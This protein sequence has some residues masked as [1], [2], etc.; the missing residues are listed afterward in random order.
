MQK[1]V[2]WNKGICHLSEEAKKRISEASKKRILL[3]GHPKGMLGKK[4][5]KKAI[6]KIKKWKPSLEQINKMAHRKS[7]HPGWKG[8]DVIS[9]CPICGKIIKSRPTELKKY[10][11]YKCLGISKRKPKNK[12]V[13]CGKILPR[14]ESK[15]C[16]VCN[17]KLKIGDKSHLWKGGISPINTRIRQSSKFKKWRKSV[18]ERDKYTCQSCFE[19]GGTLHPHHIKPFA[20]FPKLRFEL[21]NGITL[22]EDC[23]REIHKLTN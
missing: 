13:D 12:C 5:S 23:H 18:F 17:G 10:C 6:A 7:E 20:K 11:S 22:C 15:R 8:N 21:N 16:T 4:H 9:N 1:R 3:N 2:A 14:K 19:K